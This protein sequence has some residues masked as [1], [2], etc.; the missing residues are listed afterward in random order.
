MESIQKVF[1]KVSGFLTGRHG[2]LRLALLFLTLLSMKYLFP[3]ESHTA[4]A[5]LHMWTTKTGVTNSGLSLATLMKA[6]DLFSLVAFGFFLVCRVLRSFRPW[7]HL[8]SIA[9]S[10]FEHGLAAAFWLTL[11]W[12]AGTLLE[13][14]VYPGDFKNISLFHLPI[15]SIAV[16]SVMQFMPQLTKHR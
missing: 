2:L 4:I 5:S 6:L 16:I 12:V 10:S 3:E 14:P 13:L 8:A 11:I 1:E 15:V 9:N 7:Y